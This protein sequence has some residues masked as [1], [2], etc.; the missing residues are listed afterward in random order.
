MRIG[1]GREP[2][3]Q[4]PPGRLAGRLYRLPGNAG[5]GRPGRRSG[6]LRLDPPHMPVTRAAL[7]AGVPVGLEVGGATSLFECFELV[8]L[9]EETGVPCMLLENCCYGREE[10]A[11][12][13]MIKLGVLGEIIH[14]A[15]GYRMTCGRRSPRAGKPALSPRQLSASQRRQLSHARHRPYCPVPGDQPREP[16]FVSFLGGEQISGAA[17]LAAAICLPITPCRSE[18][19]T[20][21]MW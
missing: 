7:K 6:R 2:I 1:C 16:V 9:S 11:V 13:H 5:G 18:R 10:M 20:R 19:S 17:Q 21:P 12:L 14:C 3:G 8:R 15:C 4:R